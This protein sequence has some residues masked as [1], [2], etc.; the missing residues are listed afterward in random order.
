[1]TETLT[2]D[3]DLKDTLLQD[4]KSI[5][6]PKLG[7]NRYGGFLGISVLARRDIFE[8][9]SVI[10]NTKSQSILWIKLDKNVFGHE[11]IVGAMYL[12]HEGSKYH[13]DAIFE[14][15]QDDILMI[16]LRYNLP[17]CLMGD[18]N[19]RTGLC[20]DFIH[21]DPHMAELTGLDTETDEFCDMKATLNAQGICTERFNCDNVVNNNGQNLIDCCRTYDLRIVNGRFGDDKNIGSYTCYNKNNGKSVVDYAIVSDSLLPM[22]SGFEVGSFD[23]CMS[24]VHCP[25]NLYLTSNIE[26]LSNCDMQKHTHDISST[27]CT[28]ENILCSH[29]IRFNWDKEKADK[30]V[31]SFRNVDL[32]ELKTDLLELEDNA[33]QSNMDNFCKKLCD[34]F[35]ENATEA[36]ACKKIKR[37]TNKNKGFNKKPSSKPWFDE[38]CRERRSEYYKVRNQLK[39]HVDSETALKF[40]GKKYKRFINSKSKKYF[41]EFNKKL[42]NLK[43][44]NPKEYWSILN[45]SIEGKQAVSKISI[46]CFANHFKK[47]GEVNDSGDIETPFDPGS[48]DHSINEELNKD[49]T[50]AELKL[51]ISKLKSNKACGIDNIRNEFLKYCSSEMLE[52]IT[53]LFN[54]VLQRGIIPS[55]WCVGL[56]MPLYKNKGS[57]ND[58]DNYRGITLLSCIGKLFTAAVNHRLTNYLEQSGAIGDEQAGFRA[59]FSTVDH[60][61][62][63]HAIIDLYLYK[64]ERLY[65]AFIDYKKAFDL[66][67][68]SRLWMKLI[69][70]GINGRIVNAIYNLYKNAKSCV[71]HNGA[72]SDSFACNVG[73]RQ[74]ENL[75]PMLF[76]IYLNDFELYLRN[77]Y[78]GL[79]GISIEAKNYLCDDD[80]EIFL[81]LYVLLY[82][83][84]TIVMAETPKELQ[85]ALNAVYN[86]CSTWKLTVNTSKTKIVIFSRGKVRNYPN[87]M[88]GTDVLEVVDD[89]T[90]LGITF[91]YNGKFKKAIDKQMSSAR[92]ALFILQKKAKVLRLPIDVQLELFDKTVLP[93][94]LYGAE[95]W[96]FSKHK[97]R[98]EIFYRKFLKSVLHVNNRTP[99]PMV[100]GETG[101]VHI[102]LSIK[103]R[104]VNFWMRLL[105]GKQTKLSVL[106]YNII[107]A[108]HDDPT[109]EYKSDWITFIKNILDA[110][111]FSNIWHE[112]PFIFSQ[113]QEPV[114]YANW[115]KNALHLR[116]LD[117]FK[118]DWNSQMQNNRHCSNYRIF[119]DVLQFEPYLCSLNDT[120]RINLC[121]FRCRSTKL[122]ISTSFVYNVDNEM[123]KLCELNET[124]DEFHYIMKC[125]YFSNVRKK[126]LK[127]DCKRINCL[128]M[129]KIFMCK[130]TSKL[131]SLAGLIKLILSNCTSSINVRDKDKKSCNDS[132]AY[133]PKLKTRA[134]RITQKPTVL[135]L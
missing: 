127:I 46:E 105:H 7:N 110:S 130:S 99:D 21:F 69:S 4:Y 22:I 86:Y 71:K 44:N 131:K 88:F 15:L 111:G 52:I 9:I 117:I 56:I 23:N 34:V 90:Y 42:K 129:K 2:D 115:F 16:K 3:P 112:A 116:L 39:K 32:I 18:S 50:V 38:E 113:T 67:D 78:N 118:Q 1:M 128:Q 59:G 13:S 45:K 17:V 40:E 49:F 11:F 64:K 51:L 25:L 87:I 97:E 85:D 102:D 74:G 94:L 92:R 30:F 24:D 84:D 108:K 54:I 96:G 31:E 65:C 100:Y 58:P 114:K 36:G 8:Y 119:K 37:A 101:K 12:P 27:T 107:R 122:P 133:I 62:T 82:A 93:I 77:S 106:L 14:N 123:C 73:V 66:V 124:G 53:V 76:A 80:I 55:D 6:L 83:D 48:V 70:N 91:N 20:D 43:S 29:D 61:F 125:P 57:P 41:K 33:C 79:D 26:N 35:I 135:D 126:L 120:D 47:L 134:G 63:L 103:E 60:I 109:S 19:A 104:M 81:K 89:Y 68:R 72:I 132:L 10:N 75:S 98:I 95:V 121:Q 28:E 5:N